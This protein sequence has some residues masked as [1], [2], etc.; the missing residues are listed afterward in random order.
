MANTNKYP[1]EEISLNEDE[2]SL[3]KECGKVSVDFIS[4]NLDKVSQN[5]AA[6][7]RSLVDHVY[8]DKGKQVITDI[9]TGRR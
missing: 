4:E 7:V 1:K 6:F 2:V 3:L 9:L 8:S 5:P